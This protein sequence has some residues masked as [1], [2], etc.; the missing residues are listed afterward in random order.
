MVFVQLSCCS[1]RLFCLAELTLLLCKLGADPSARNDDGK[2]PSRLVSACT[3]NKCECIC[4]KVWSF[5]C[6]AA[7]TKRILR[8]ALFWKFTLALLLPWRLCSLLLFRSSPSPSVPPK[9]VKA[10]ARLAVEA[11][12]P[13]IPRYSQVG[14]GLAGW[15]VSVAIALIAT[16]LSFWCHALLP[17]LTF[18]TS[19]PSTSSP[20]S[21]RRWKLSW[22][23][24]ILS[25]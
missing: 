4:N 11:A 15:H 2:R 24:A 8:W 16:V 17:T 18:C 13:R 7:R 1:P 21:F 22:P 12:I 9:L 3:Q 14:G 6:R 10:R 23:T 25:T 5:G 19:S 20:S